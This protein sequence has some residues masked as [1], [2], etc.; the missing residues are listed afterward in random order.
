M[1]TWD[2]ILNE[3]E[4]LNPLTVL[5]KYIKKLYERTQRTTICYMSA[6]TVLKPPVP[7]PFHS[8]IDQDIQGL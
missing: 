2:K 5:E 4:N 3:I 1:P 8:I 6:F 7:T